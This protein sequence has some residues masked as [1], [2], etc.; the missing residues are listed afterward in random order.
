MS[1]MTQFNSEL[2]G[3]EHLVIEDEEASTDIRARRNFGSNV[4]L[5]C[6][7]REQSAH[8]KNRE[9]ITLP[10]I[11]RLSISV[12]DEPENLLILPPIDESLEDKFI[13][14]KC[15]KAPMPWPTVT[16]AEREA[17]MAALHA[18]LSH[19]LFDLLR[20]EIPREL[21]SQRYGITHYQHPDIMESITNLTPESRL[22]E[23]IDSELFGSAAP[24]DWEGSAT[25][26]E[27]RLRSPNSNV[28]QEAE[29]LFTFPLACGT[30]LGRLQKRDKK[31]RFASFH[32]QNGNT[33]TI[34][35]P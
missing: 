34:S 1:G 15:R 10:P 16:L 21:V 7:N 22:L 28:K 13:I 18:E 23:L 12:N 3:A 29:R 19:F 33:W 2:M 17:F 24:S 20:W 9:A 32:R 14:L 11:W 4:K 25:E 27:R 30:Y 8:G 5:V 31:N 35:P 26:L 6:A